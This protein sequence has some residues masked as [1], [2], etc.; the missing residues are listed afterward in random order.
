MHTTIVGGAM[1]PHA[2]QFFTLPDT[3]DRDTVARVKK[4][5]KQIGDRLKALEP[6]LWIISDHD[7][8]L[9]SSAPH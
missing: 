5:A 2:P 4:V 7:R 3:E 8:E 1:L 6:D 9:R